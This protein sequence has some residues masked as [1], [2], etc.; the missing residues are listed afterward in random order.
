MITAIVQFKLP[1]PITRE[2]AREIF[3]STAPKYQ[4]I[5]GLIR[6]YYLLSE[7]GGTAGG[8][9]TWASR[10]EAERLYTREWREFI[11]TKYG[12]EPSVTFFE[13][14]VLV[15]NVQKEIVLDP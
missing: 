3:A 8:A 1:Q 9:Y 4:E 2:Q 5:P 12:C 7:D 11:M 10:E 15:D 6:K 14:P 13:T